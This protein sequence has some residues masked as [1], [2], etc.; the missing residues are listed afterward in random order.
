MIDNSIQSLSLIE[1]FYF[2]QVV[3]EL[4][5]LLERKNIPGPYLFVGREEGGQIAKAAAIT[6]P[7]MTAGLVLIDSYPFKTE[8]EL[9]GQVLGYDAY[10][11][12]LDYIRAHDAARAFEVVGFSRYGI[13][14]LF[15]YRSNA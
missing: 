4:F 1:F 2:R 9:R 10:L 15:C 6:S 7:T 8:Q 3:A 13:N 11:R 5:Q 14:I 12:Q